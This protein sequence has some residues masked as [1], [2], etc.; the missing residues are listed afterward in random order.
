MPIGY[1]LRMADSRSRNNRRSDLL[2]SCG[3][4]RRHQMTSAARHPCG[5]K[6]WSESEP[7]A[8]QAPR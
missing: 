6:M 7:R 4:E 5:L 1:G 2:G 8:V 3:V